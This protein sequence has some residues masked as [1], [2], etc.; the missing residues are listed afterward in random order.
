MSHRRRLVAW[1]SVGLAC[2]AMIITAIPS[3]GR[4]SAATTASGS[5]PI[6]QYGTVVYVADGDTIDVKIDGVAPDPGREGTR[7]RFLGTQA[8]ELYTYHENLSLVTGE[9]HAPEAAKLLKS[10]L[11]SSDGAGQRVR[12]TAQDASSSNL[13]RVA[14]FVAIKGTGGTWHDVGAIMIT[15]GEAIPS[16][17]KIDYQ[18]NERYRQ[19]AEAAAAKRIGIW[20]THYCGKG[21]AADLSVRVNWDAPGNDAINVNGEYIKIT[22]LGASTVNLAGWW[23]RDSG[24]RPMPT[25]LESK[26]GYILPRG[27]EVAP[28]ASL[29][30]HVGRGTAAPATGQF[31]YGLNAP[32]F[33]NVTGA[34]TYMGDGAYL[35]DPKGDLRGWQ[36][37]PCVS[38]E[39]HACTS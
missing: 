4:A 5:G 25:M 1:G 27:A 2:L 6:I 23:V 21:P 39:P 17:Q 37:Y 15:K 34:P 29:F 38:T 19:M 10:L 14:R 3:A 13:G 9:C 32:I 28:G 8:L 26:R 33:E 16:Y 18:W 36:Q 35:F 31:Y 24:T 12:L 7:I 30:V 20:D 22:N 11:M